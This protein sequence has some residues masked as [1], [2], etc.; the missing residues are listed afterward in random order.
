M[1]A[2]VL[3]HKVSY[4]NVSADKMFVNGKLKNVLSFAVG[5]KRFY[6]FL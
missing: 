1:K 5:Y 3:N 2:L 6:F 4:F